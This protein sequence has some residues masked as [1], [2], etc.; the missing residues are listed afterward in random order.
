MKPVDLVR[1]V[2]ALASDGYMQMTYPRAL[3]ADDAEDIFHHLALVQRQLERVVA[4]ENVEPDIDVC[5]QCGG[6]ADRGFNREVPPV[7][8]VCSKCGREC[9]GCGCELPEPVM[10]SISHTIKP[11]EQLCSGCGLKESCDP[12]WAEGRRV[13]WIRSDAASAVLDEKERDGRD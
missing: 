7:P 10:C 4:A 12:A 13:A 6:P 5:P 11:G 1:H 2:C 3:T 9:P 8:Y